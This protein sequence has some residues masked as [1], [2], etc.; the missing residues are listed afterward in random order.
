MLRA[1]RQV[2]RRAQRALGREHGF[3]LIEAVL[4]M[5][6]FA[7]VVTAL[8]GVLT[9]SISARSLASQ[10]TAAEQIANDQIE[11]IRSLD[12]DTEVGLTGAANPNGVV[13]PT[14]DQSAQGG[15]TVPAKYT[16]T[17]T[18]KW[19]DDPVPTAFVTHANYKNVTVSVFRATDSKRLT[20]Q[21]TVIS[22]RQKVALGGINKGTV[23]ALVQDYLSPKN[24]HPGVTV[25]LS[26]G[27]SSPLSDAT[28]SSGKVTFPRLDPATGSTYY[29]LV[30]PT[31]SGGWIALPDAATTHF[32][33]AAGATPSTK[34]LQVYKP[35][36]LTFQPQNSSGTPFSSAAVF[37]VSGPEGT[38]DFTYTAGAGPITVTSLTKA[39][40]TI[41]LPPGVYTITPKSGMYAD[42]VT[43]N[44]PAN[45]GNYP[46]DLAASASITSDPLGTIS[47]TVTSAGTGTLIAGATVTVAGGPRSVATQ[48]ATTNSSG[49][50]TF[51]GLPAGSGYTVTAAKGTWSA[52]NQTASVSGGSVTNLAFALPQGHLKAVVSWAGTP[53]LG[54]TVTLTGGGGGV[55]L[56]GTSDSTGAV[57]FSNV[58][59]GSGYTLSATVAT[60]QT[61]TVSPTVVGGTTTTVSVPMP[62]VSLVATVAWANN[63]S[64]SGATVSLSG[65]PMSL[66]TISATTTSGGQVTFNNVPAGTGYTLSA[67]KNGQTTTLTSQTVT[68]SPTTSIGIALPT[69]TITTTATW[70]GQPAGSATVT[71]TAGPDGGTYTGTTNSSGVAAVTVPATT[72]TYPFT[73]TVTKNTGSG[74]TSVSTVGTGA[75]V[76]AGVTMTP[77]GTIA[78]TA[79]SLTW[80]GQFVPSASVTI[81][82][83]PNAGA[84]YTGT[85]SATGVLNVT[86]PATSSSFPYTVAISKNG[87]TGSNGAVAAPASGATVTATV[88]LTPTKV[89]TVT[90]ATNS[91]I[92]ITGGPNGAAGSA[93]TY[94]GVTTATTSVAIT[95]PVGTG[96]YTVR[97]HNT[98]CSA[99]GNKSGSATVSSL[100]APT[101]VTVTY[102]TATCPG[103]TP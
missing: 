66:S 20:Q 26:N 67:T 41:P 74:S 73:V 42:P 32:Q 11:W 85:T 56:S 45:F 90:V 39:G 64:V 78:L 61:A 48:T 84:T 101:T 81:T 46:G 29:D 98:P 14:G 51:T 24:P 1:G 50:A 2:I 70:A 69:G 87:G 86:V 28:D 58:A 21:S 83:G 88:A 62:T 36:T 75:N 40:V 5:A 91:S 35:V 77:T 7:A 30:V 57:L 68:T 89:L 76:A 3:T 4:A 93:P 19:V 94:S 33:L 53:V 71:I 6:I 43:Q 54:A 100:A 38:D 9:S 47:A 18:I 95:V 27:P 15:P 10:R 102:S 23:V 31:F 79:A 12:Y 8:G 97:A 16:A 99:A 60:G 13:N 17:I 44:V 92:T 96:T 65:G 25:N 49:V 59:S 80:A 55:S 82:G 52:P 63:G 37:T 103:P 34:V 22:P 72:S